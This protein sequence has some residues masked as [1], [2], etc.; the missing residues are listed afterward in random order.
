MQKGEEGKVRNS[1]FGDSLRGQ[2]TVA[3][4]RPAERR[5]AAPRSG[6][7]HLRDWVASWAPPALLNSWG[8]PASDFRLCSKSQVQVLTA[9][10]LPDFGKVPFHLCAYLCA[11]RDLARRGTHTRNAVYYAGHRAL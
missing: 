3:E 1:G 10:P 7:A 9:P 5:P 2:I 8:I 4:I 6:P 11:E